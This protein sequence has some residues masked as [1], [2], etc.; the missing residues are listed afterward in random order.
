MGGVVEG[1][2]F[3]FLLVLVVSRRWSRAFFSCFCEGVK[4]AAIKHVQT[5]EAA[6][7]EPTA[8]IRRQADLERAQIRYL[9]D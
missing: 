2:F 3:L 8:R 9:R 6:C 7:R 1:G 5:L 4:G